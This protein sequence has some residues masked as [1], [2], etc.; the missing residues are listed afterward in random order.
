M[1]CV[2]FHLLLLSLLDDRDNTLVVLCLGC[3]AVFAAVAKAGRAH[4][5]P[6]W[7]FLLL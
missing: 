2:L 4:F 3:F 6:V 1:A 5:P 7:N